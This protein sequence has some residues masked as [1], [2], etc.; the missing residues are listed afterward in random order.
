MI[1]LT[2]MISHNSGLSAVRGT[3]IVAQPKLSEVYI[4]L[5]HLKQGKPSLYFEQVLFIGESRCS[6]SL[7]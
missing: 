7:L 4:I 2:I 6:E 3:S 5:P 1:S